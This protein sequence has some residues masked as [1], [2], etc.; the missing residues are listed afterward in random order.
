MPSSGLPV[1]CARSSARRDVRRRG[2][3]GVSEEGL[4]D[5]SGLK[6]GMFSPNVYFFARRRRGK[7]AY[8]DASLLI[9]EQSLD[10]TLE[11]GIFRL[12]ERANGVRRGVARRER[13]CG[14]IAELVG[15][16]RRFHGD[17]G[18]FGAR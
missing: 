12:F 9:S 10:A 13:A 1:G 16:K 11:R 5:G 6:G 7:R 18:E 8:M 15:R 4:D 3:G 17:A 2:D 14:V